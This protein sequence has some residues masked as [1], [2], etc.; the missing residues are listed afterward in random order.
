MDSDISRWVLEFLLRSSVPDSLIQ[1]ALTSLPLSGA[2]L[3]LK[4]TLLLRTLHTLLLH[5]S[6]PDTALHILELLEPHSNDASA[7]SLRRAY[8]A[9]AV[10]CTVKYLAAVPDAPSAEYSAA[11]DRIWRGRVAALEARRSGIASSGELARWRDD[12]EAAVWDPRVRERL[13][14]LNSRKEAFDEVGA[15]LKEAWEAMGP[16]FLESMSN[17]KGQEGLENSAKEKERSDYDDDDGDAC[18]K[19]LAT[20]DGNEEVGG[21]D[22]PPQRGKETQKRKSQL[23]HKHSALRTCNRGVKISD[24]EEVEPAKWKSKHDP[25]PSAEASKVRESLKSS[26]LELQALVEDP[27]PDALHKSEVIRSK[28]ATRDTNIEPPIENQSEDV[29]VPDPDVCRSIVLFQPKDANLV[30][31]SPDPCSNVH[32][33]NIMER[34][35]TARTYEWEDSTDNSSQARQTRRRKRKWSSLEEETLRA[36]VQMFG[37]GNWA[38]IRSFYSNVFENRSGVDLKD[39]WRNMIR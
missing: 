14:G 33:P 9:V 27:L 19:N 31:K 30:K 16:S 3:R 36:G 35:R 1:K 37:E 12:V 25:V 32:Q 34:N 17:A 4:H 10:E 6:L 39:K 29:D 5:A 13:A 15:Y 18:M 23:K 11:V 22:L 20:R 38:T 28:S 24:P 7:A 8:R 2:D 21:G 26:S